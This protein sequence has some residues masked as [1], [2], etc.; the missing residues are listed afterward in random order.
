MLVTKNSV[1]PSDVFSVLFYLSIA[2]EYISCNSNLEKVPCR[3]YIFVYI[4]KER[5]AIAW[6]CL[7]SCRKT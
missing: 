6:F 2:V 5:I 7:N 1:V 3:E 4:L